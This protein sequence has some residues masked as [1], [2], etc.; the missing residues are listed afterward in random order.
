M[1]EN[2]VT[3]YFFSFACGMVDAICYA[4]LGGVFVSLMTGNRIPLGVA[5]GQLM[6]LETYYSFL[7]PLVTYGL[8]SY[9]G[10]WVTQRFPTHRTP[11][12]GFFSI[13]LLLAIATLLSSVI[14]PLVHNIEYFLLLANLGFASG[15]QSALLQKAGLK[16]FASN[17][18]TSTLTSMLADFPVKSDKPRALFGGRLLS[19]LFFLLGAITGA[20]TVNFG[21]TLALGLALVPLAIAVFGVMIA[22][23]SVRE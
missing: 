20:F 15:L 8:G 3:Y 22:Q 16:N 2:K 14:D 17:V 6:P 1:N 4:K 23:S 5:V 10:G 9:V 7:I 18:M 12:L 11:K 19:I 21:L 13:W